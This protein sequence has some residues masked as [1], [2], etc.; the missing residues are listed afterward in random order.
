MTKIS[1]QKKLEAILEYFSG[2][3]S[4]QEVAKRYGIHYTSFKM[5]LAAYKTHGSDVLFNPPKPTG[6]FRVELASWAIRNNASNTEVAAKFGYVG[7][8]QIV[9]WKEIYSQLGP[10]GLLSIQKGRKPKMPNKKPKSDK[11]LTDQ[12]NQL[13][14]LEDEVLRLKIENE[15]LKLLA[16]IQQR[17]DNS[18]K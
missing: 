6:K 14:Q 9:K 18:Q 4:K 8:A 11:P 3:K 2:N 12:E 16:S 13:A 15:A 7:T 10:N 5:L 1:K 17:T